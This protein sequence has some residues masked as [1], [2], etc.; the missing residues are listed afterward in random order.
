MKKYIITLA[1]FCLQFSIFNSGEIYAQGFNS[2][3][4]PDGVNLVAVGN[5][6]KLYRSANGGSTWLSSINGALNMN[7][8]TSLGNDVWIAA[9]GGKVYKT[10]KTSSPINTYSAGAANLNSIFFIDANTGFVCGDGGVVYKSLNGGLT[11]SL[12][13]TGIASSKLNSISFK[14]A[15]NGTV[16]GNNGNIFNTNDG[17]LSWTPQTSGTAYSLL[18]VKYFNNDLV[19]VGEYG[20]LLQSSGSVWTPVNT[21][22]KSDIRGV[23]GTS[24]GDVH[25]C[26]GGGFIRN[27]KSGSLDF[28]NFEQN[29]MMANLVDI[30]YYDNNNG[31][32]VSSLNS[33]IIYTTD[34]GTSWG[35]PAGA[36]VS[37]S[38]IT[39]LNVG[40]GIGNNL[41][42]HPFNRDALFVVYGSTVY[43]SGDK[44]DTWTN[45]A[46]VSG[47]GSAHS[48][49][50]SPL[51]TNIWVVAIT[52]STD[53]IKRTTNYGSTW[54]DV[55]SANFSNYGQPLEMDQNNPSNYYFAPDNGGFYRSTDNA[56]SFQEI[57]GNYPFR[58][59]CDII[60]MWDSSDVI[61][62][63]DG[64]TGSGQADIFKS[65]NNGVN[66]TNIISTASSEV[67]SMCNSV[68]EQN[69]VYATNWG[70]GQLYK[71]TNF[72][73]SFYLLSTQS[74]SGWGS[75]VCHE[76]PTLVLKGTYGS[77]TWLSTNSGTSFIS[78]PVGGSAGA[79]IIVPDRG[80]LIAMQSGGLL[81]MA[82]TYT[83][84]PTIINIDVQSTSIGASGV[85]YFPTATISPTG[86]VKNNNGGASAT[87]NVTRKITPGGYVSTKAVINLA[88]ISSTNVTFDPWTF[89]SGTTYTVKDSVYI[90][91]D[92]NTS[93]DVLSGTIT[94]YVGDNVNIFTQPFTGTFPPSGW[95]LGGS[96]GTMY[97]IYN[98]ASS[99]GNGTGSAMYNFYNSPAGRNQTMTST[100]FTAA[101]SGDKLTFDYAYA[102]FTSGTDSLLIQISSN[103]GTSY[104]NLTK[105]YGKAGY[106]GDSTLN[107]APTN[108]SEFFAGKNDWLT[109]TYTLPVGTN[110]V[111][112]R[113]RSGFG[114][115]LFV[116]NISV[117]SGNL[118]TQLNL[119]LAP[120]GFY[121]G[122][123]LNMQ[124][125]ITA[126]LRN[127][128]TPFAVVDS[129]KTTLNAVTLT[130]AC[131]F[132]YAPTGTY[133]YQ[134]IH[135]NAL[136]TWSET[137]GETITKGVTSG[138]DFTTLQARSYG[139][140][141][142][143]KFTKWCLY[144]GDVNRDG[145]VDLSDL[146]SID[147][148]A[149]NFV[150]GYVVTDL[151]GDGTTDISDA[152]IAD[153]NAS[154][155]VSKI[156]PATSPND[157]Q[158]LKEKSKQKIEQRKLKHSENN[159]LL[160]SRS[161]V[162]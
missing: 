85:N 129:A 120:E 102:P 68:F 111:R 52:G 67:P 9:N 134:I 148:D 113:A 60:V 59:P 58:S 123:T 116:D 99:Y 97:W 128:I 136:E 34:G 81:K 143:L 162:K 86:T 87:F 115:N 152:A 146:S 14:N 46:S 21:R 51:D 105:L 158:S 108:G 127:T 57:S 30:F 8:V 121:N 107:T 72:G 119:T 56:A 75:D 142:V 3:T 53:K 95:T 78:T 70:G 6:G 2:I 137:G 133:Y 147:N 74:S 13:N 118:Y 37:Y 106:R 159:K 19:A 23:T 138:Y 114:N 83:D 94:P 151:T 55:L 100:T 38:W 25:V 11:W 50:V 12:S 5:S 26:G 76:D 132:K 41:S 22:T 48:F 150:S 63:G 110:R 73:N 90:T 35:M 40:G 15:N 131:V 156:T 91:D 135:R 64:I 145:T 144:S 88:P 140:N 139:S 84:N 155:F 141:S 18:K 130:A 77:P 10:L 80:Y 125:T 71:T 54:T 17:G 16:V 153:N 160:N 161:A 69:V 36:A 42:E 117:S 44:G 92:A 24:I 43:R 61:F 39:K 157:A 101:I 124:D 4:T 82:I 66:W 98:S 33:V 47:G 89:S 109:K 104:T 62:I 65:T 32:A 149:Y 154:N 49:Y 28:Y 1:L 7:S 93:N 79:G 27:N 29:P 96:T 126:Y 31:W 122:I 45:I 20:T 112:F 103:G